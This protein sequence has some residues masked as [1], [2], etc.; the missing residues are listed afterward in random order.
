MV[1]RCPINFP[2]KN[3]IQLTTFAKRYIFIL[4]LI[5]LFF[6]ACALVNYSPV[7]RVKISGCHIRIILSAP[8]I[9]GEMIGYS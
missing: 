4:L 8:K 2:E 6:K 9:L 5:K 7:G 3:K 1:K